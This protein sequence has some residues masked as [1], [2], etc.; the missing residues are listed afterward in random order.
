MKVTKIEK[1][2]LEAFANGWH[3]RNE[4]PGRWNTYHSL[5][6]KGLVESAFRPVTLVTPMGELELSRKQE[7]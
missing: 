4:I 2:M 5:V 1:K 7:D 6:R 3:K